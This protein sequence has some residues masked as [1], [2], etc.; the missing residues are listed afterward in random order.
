MVVVHDGVLVKEAVWE[1][2]CKRQRVKSEDKAKGKSLIPFEGRHS[3]TK[4]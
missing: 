3:G 1:T 2:T 4:T